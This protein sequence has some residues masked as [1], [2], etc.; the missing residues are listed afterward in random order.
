MRLLI[1]LDQEWSQIRGNRSSRE[2]S[3][4]EIEKEEIVANAEVKNS[5]E[6]DSKRKKKQNEA[7]KKKMVMQMYNLVK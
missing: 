7:R 2:L 3:A 6:W 1:V 5:I 4:K